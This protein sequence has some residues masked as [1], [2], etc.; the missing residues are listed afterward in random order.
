MIANLFF[1]L[2]TTLCLAT[3]ASA[4]TIPVYDA[5]ALPTAMV[6]TRVAPCGIQIAAD[7][8]W[9]RT[10]E[11]YQDSNGKKTN[12]VIYK[13]EQSFFNNLGPEAAK[14]NLNPRL[15]IIVRCSDSDLSEGGSF[16]GL[17]FYAERFHSS[18]RDRNGSKPTKLEKQQVAGLGT[19]YT[20]IEPAKG[21]DGGWTDTAHFAALHQGKL[22]TISLRVSRTAGKS[23]RKRIRAG[24]N[25]TLR[26][27]DGSTFTYQT[28]T[29]ARQDNRTSVVAYDRSQAQNIALFDAFFSV[30]KGI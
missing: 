27:E 1:V 25:V 7:P 30:L 23:Y 21:K 18:A 5:N 26:Y 8:K 6:P 2:C 14:Y 10:T 28:A 13:V 20:H 11:T 19:V 3:V 12:E 4:E 22:V 24:K 29:D 15:D 16:D 17:A 9:P